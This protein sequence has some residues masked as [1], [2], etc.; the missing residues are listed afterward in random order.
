M[1]DGTPFVARLAVQEF[2]MHRVVYND[3]ASIFET[4]NNEQNQKTTPTEYFQANIDYPLAREVTYMDFPLCLHG[5][6]GRKNGPSG[7]EGAVSGAF[8]SLVLPLAN[9]ISYIHY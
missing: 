6:M 7:R 2:G 3:N 8:I 4:V 9:G 5:P 1:H